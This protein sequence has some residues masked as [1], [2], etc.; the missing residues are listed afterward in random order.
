MNGW[1]PRLLATVVA[2]ALVATGCAAEQGTVVQATFDDVVDLTPRGAVKIADVTVG[3]IRE[4]E[5]TEQH[6]ALVTLDVDPDVALPARVTARLRKT[7][8]LGERFVELVPDTD[9]GGRFVSGSMVD[10]TVVVP[11][12]EEVVF[13]G[14]E[15][16]AAIAADR[17][18]GAIEAGAEGLG[19]RGGT[20]DTVLDD[21]SEIVATYSANQD[22][23]VRL[24]DGFEGFLAEVGPEADLHGQALAE[25]LR[26]NQVLSAEDE[27]LLDTLS[28]IRAL[29]GTGTDIIT[30][31]RQR[32]DDFFIRFS[33][34][35]AEIAS[36]DED[37]SRLFVAMQ[38]HNNSTIEGINSEHAQI[39]LDFI[40]CGINDE[41]A[42]PI[43]SCEEQA[44][45][46]MGRP[47]PVPPQDFSP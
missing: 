3:S 43:R 47:Q 28:E 31:H 45:S 33:R 20:L 17:L 2:L 5:L 46:G 26:F 10:E 8:V 38:R 11:E 6:R 24:I 7:N 18:A 21:L 30:A 9:S 35:S 41:P 1:L 32:I 42:D 36:R 37:L 12:L 34:L 22:D 15:V 29:A 44:P 4:I 19:G 27:R 40:I 13:A 25:L 39:I 23:I 16:V 14:T